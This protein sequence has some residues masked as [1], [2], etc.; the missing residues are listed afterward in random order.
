MTFIAHLVLLALAVPAAAASLYLLVF[1]LL[2]AALPRV[3][4]SSRRLRFDVIVPAHDEA[5]VIEAAVASLR[6]IDWPAE[7]FRILVV[8][9]NCSDAT[10][11]L[12][13]AAGAD[14]I[15]RFDPE[16]RG[17]G[18]ALALGFQHSQARKWADAVVVVDAD[19]QV[20][21]NLLE[22]FAARIEAGAK[23]VQAHYGV[24]NPHASWRTRLMTIAMASFHRVRSRA[25][26]RLQLSCGLRGN[27]W[28]VTHRLLRQ[29]PYKAYSL[30][31]DVEYGI[32]LG[33]AGYRVHYADEAHVAGIMVS[34]EQA[35]RTQR[36]RWE[37]GRVQLIRTRVVPLLKA[38]TGPDGGV[39]LDL[40]LDLLVLPLSYVAAN[41][42][43][44]IMLAGLGTLAA[45]SLEPWLWLGLACA[46]SL[47]FYV[48]RGWSLSGVGLRGL[49]DLLRAPFFVIWKLLSM[50]RPHNSAEWV[51]T[52]R[53]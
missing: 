29:V 37:D 24:S 44:L 34:G 31:E 4:S 51:R 14:V 43:L 7:S 32:D 18:Y 30:A 50:L 17:K 46:A 33:L 22:A 27:G 10:A 39:C 28:C 40:A 49:V 5:A 48:L 1:T 25:R 11:A 26:E 13:R 12:A 36:Q 15:E 8:A 6:K 35:S 16:L 21:A 42:A 23:A 3:L 2:S 38:A 20:S 41:V 52:K 47:A 45:P 19:T 53:E 9:D